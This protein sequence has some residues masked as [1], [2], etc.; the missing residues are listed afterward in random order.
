M[1]NNDNEKNYALLLKKFN[2]KDQQS[3][4]IVY[5]TYYKEFSHF[6]NRLFY[7][8]QHSSDDVLQDI[9]ISI[10]NNKSRVFES[11]DNLKVYIYVALKNKLK[12]LANHQK[13]MDK[14]NAVFK[15]ETSFSSY[16]AESEVV[17][18]ISEAEG[19]IPSECA[20]VFRL[21]FEGWDVKEIAKMLNK[22]ESTVYKQKREAISI[23]KKNLNIKK[24]LLLL[25]YL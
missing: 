13:C 5:L 3:F 24:L 2:S 15:I 19:L 1:V 11:F 20:K 4:G 7:N 18:I 22:S 10:W 9:F 23:L 14:Y 6:A 21:H 16:V 17:A 8:T 25:N 12:E